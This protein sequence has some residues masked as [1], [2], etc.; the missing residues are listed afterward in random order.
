[1]TYDLAVWA[2]DRP[3]TDAKAARVFHHLYDRF[4]TECGHVPV[5]PL[6]DQYAEALVDRWAHVESQG[7]MHSPWISGP[8]LG[9]ASGPLLYFTVRSSR[10][11][12]VVTFA[13][14]VAAEFGLVCFDP[15]TGELR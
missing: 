9:S 12:E 10:A 3:L 6:I 1:M 15:Q 8:H 2:G 7:N 11:A 5:L 13:A 14:N 4:M